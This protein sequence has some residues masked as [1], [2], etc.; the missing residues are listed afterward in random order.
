MHT[1]IQG[2]IDQH[3]VMK[4]FVIEIIILGRKIEGERKVEAETGGLAQS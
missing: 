4:Q 3:L 1:E 2:D